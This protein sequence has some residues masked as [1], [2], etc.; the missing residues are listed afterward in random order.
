MGEDSVKPFL[1]KDKWAILLALTSNKGSQD[2]QFISSA[3]NGRP[4]YEEV[5]TK[6][7]AWGSPDELMYVV[8]ATQGDRISAIR[9]L[10]PEHFFLIPGIGAQGGDLELV[11]NAMNRQCGLIVNSAR[12]IIYA[13]DGVDFADRARKEAQ[14]IR[15]NMYKLLQQ[16]P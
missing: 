9:N 13:S 8:G 1:L 15:A 7:Q 4:L 14:L 12:S 5:I 6:S 10:A 11:A 3:A 2:F 16:I